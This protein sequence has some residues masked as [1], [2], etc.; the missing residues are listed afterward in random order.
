MNKPSFHAIAPAVGLTS[1][2][3]VMA[4]HMSN[5]KH[6]ASQDRIAAAYKSAK[7]EADFAVAKERC[8]DV[9]GNAKD[10]CVK[11]TK[12][13]QTKADATAQMKTSEAN[14]TAD[15]KSAEA[16]SKAH[17][18]A[19]SAHKEAAQDGLRRAVQGGEAT[20]RHEHARRQG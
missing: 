8:E 19:A 4:Q 12:A 9:A 5:D 15:E 1:C 18:E 11:Q 6:K 7:A 10:V 17:E 20:G 3:A 16:R 14:A 2:A 13:A